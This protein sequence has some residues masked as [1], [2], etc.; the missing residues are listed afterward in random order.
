MEPG[1]PRGPGN[2]SAEGGREEEAAAAALQVDVDSLMSGTA[3]PLT[4]PGGGLEGVAV[5]ESPVAALAASSRSPS[6]SLSGALSVGGGP[7]ALPSSFDYRKAPSASSRGS[8]GRAGS[9]GAGRTLGGSE[10]G[11]HSSEFSDAEAVPRVADAHVEPVSEGAQLPPLRTSGSVHSSKGSGALS[12]VAAG[13]TV[14]R[15]PGGSVA[16]QEGTPMSVTR[17]GSSKS[18]GHRGTSRGASYFD[19]PGVEHGVPPLSRVQQVSFRQSRTP[20]LSVNSPSLSAASGVAAEQPEHSALHSAP[21]NPS[22][23]ASA[24]PQSEAGVDPRRLLDAAGFH[25]GESATSQGVAAVARMTTRARRNYA[26]QFHRGDFYRRAKKLAAMRDMTFMERYDTSP[27]VYTL[28]TLF[29][30]VSILCFALETVPEIR[31]KTGGSLWVELELCFTVV[32]TFEIVLRYIAFRLSR[33]HKGDEWKQSRTKSRE[34]LLSRHALVTAHHRFWADPLVWI[35]IAAIMPFFFRWWTCTEWMEPDCKSTGASLLASIK[36]LR[37]FKLAR[38]FSGTSVL[39]LVIRRVWRV[40]LAPLLFLGVSA[41]CYACILFAVE[42]ASIGDQCDDIQVRFVDVVN[43]AYFSIVTFTTVGYG[44]VV[45]VTTPGRLV[46]LLLMMWGVLFTA[47]PLAVV[48]NEFFVV[49]AEFQEERRLER[50]PNVVRWRA[51]L[52]LPQLLESNKKQLLN[53]LQDRYM[54]LVSHTSALHR[55]T[56]TFHRGVR[57]DDEKAAK[58]TANRHLCGPEALF[59]AGFA[60]DKSIFDARQARRLLRAWVQAH[61]EFMT[62]LYNMTEPTKTTVHGTEVH[63]VVP[64]GRAIVIQHDA[65]GGKYEKVVPQRYASSDST[66]AHQRE[67]IQ[68]GQLLDSKRFKFAYSCMI[69]VSVVAFIAESTSELRETHE[70]YL[71]GTLAQRVLFH[72]LSSGFLIIWILRA[73][74]YRRTSKRRERESTFL[75]HPRKLMLL[76]AVPLV[77]WIVEV[78][79]SYAAPDAVDSYHMFVGLLT[80][81]RIPRGGQRIPGV[82][83]LTSTMAQSAEAL[84]IPLFFFMVATLLFAT[85]LYVVELEDEKQRGLDGDWWDVRETEAECEARHITDLFRAIWVVIQTITSV[86]YGN[87]HPDTM[88]GRLVATGAMVFGLVYMAMPLSLIGTAFS[89]NWTRYAEKKQPLVVPL[90]LELLDIRDKLQSASKKVASVLVRLDWKESPTSKNQH[91][92]S[93]ATTNF[94]ASFEGVRPGFGQFGSTSGFSAA[95]PLGGSEKALGDTDGSVARGHSGALGESGTLPDVAEH[96]PVSPVMRSGSGASET[97]AVELGGRATGDGESK[98][99]PESERRRRR[100]RSRKRGSVDSNSSARD[101]APTLRE[102]SV[103]GDHRARSTSQVSAWSG[104][105]HVSDDGASSIA[106]ASAVGR[107]AYSR[108][109]EPPPELVGGIEELLVAVTRAGEVMQFIHHL[110]NEY[111]ATPQGLLP[112][113]MLT[114]SRMALDRA[115]MMANIQASQRRGGVVRWLTQSVH[116]AMSENCCGRRHAPVSSS[117]FRQ[118]RS[119]PSIIAAIKEGSP[120]EETPRRPT[121]A[122]VGVSLVSETRESHDRGSASSLVDDSSSTAMHAERHDARSQ[123]A[124]S[125]TRHRDLD[126]LVRGDELERAADGSMSGLSI[127]GSIDEPSVHA[128]QGEGGVSPHEDGAISPVAE[129]RRPTE[130]VRDAS[131]SGDA[132]ETRHD[133]SG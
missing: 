19:I 55:L 118:P 130:E 36:I 101:R 40:M 1:E 115:R 59:H 57:G 81:C 119:G 58:K 37:V 24:G 62:E 12:S 105:E 49:Q 109:I 69:F 71:R 96:T 42:H 9:F 114:A 47:M 89:V 129:M 120:L 92:R 121:N 20:N 91:D 28:E 68:I 84:V 111:I 15:S 4:T 125:P 127:P 76:D 107:A 6:Q 82:R 66:V 29:I 45:P 102:L 128:M 77:A 34:Q 131:T 74:A 51:R 132:E 124:S 80:L 41:L 103:A 21:S 73:V 23:V 94:S 65:V 48:G 106:G 126:K 116:D 75:M 100:G 8:D 133:S 63:G 44:D 113:P 64:G 10:D 43:T 85:L 26:K 5:L 27:I 2:A 30:V 16:A 54:A 88:L 3:G 39:V 56:R 117:G 112:P 99:A 78:I 35:D 11:Q 86:G 70:G 50:T 90:P 7:H 53:S 61:I 87:L 72:I 98:T 22:I 60:L 25:G 79:L 33:W 83:V 13:S 93:M 110:V 122:S 108:H 52:E 123:P 18:R 95:M 17:K 31:N 32:F 67:R 97:S 14:G 46:T 104:A 38:H